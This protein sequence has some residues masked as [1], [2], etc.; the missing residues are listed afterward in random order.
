[1]TVYKLDSWSQDLNTDFTLKAFLFRGVKL[2]KNVDRDKYL[3]SGYGIGFDSRSKFSLPDGSLGKNFIIFGFDVN[4]SVN[5]YNKKKDIL[6]L[7]KD[8]TKIR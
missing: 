1:M 5:I 6:I 4:L 7:G 2:A 8:L 3:Y